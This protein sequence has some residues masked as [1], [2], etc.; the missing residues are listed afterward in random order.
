[1]FLQLQSTFG[2]SYVITPSQ[3]PRESLISPRQHS[4]KGLGAESVIHDA[5]GIKHGPPLP[6]SRPRDEQMFDLS[7]GDQCGHTTHPSLGLSLL[8]HLKQRIKR[9]WF[10]KHSLSTV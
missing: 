6:R 5:L 10:N 1:M 2:A 8:F 7:T 4:N 3:Q 9:H